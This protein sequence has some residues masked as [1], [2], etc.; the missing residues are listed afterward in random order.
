MI[1]I[2]PFG[3]RVAIEVLQPENLTSGGLLVASVS[4]EKSNKGVV[5]AIGDSEDVKNINIGDKIIFN[6]SSGLKYT[7][8]EG[9]YKIIE[10]RDIIGKIIEE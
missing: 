5:V 7:S 3:S 10:M 6:L 1:K 9:E 2:Q 8:E 4:K